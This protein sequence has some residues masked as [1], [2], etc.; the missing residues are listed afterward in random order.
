MTLTKDHL[1]DSLYT[2][3]DLPKGKSSSLIETL[4][5]IMKNQ[6]ENKEDILISGFGKFCVKDKNDRRGRNPATGEDLTLE[7]RRVVVFK[8][9]GILRK[10]I[11]GKGGMNLQR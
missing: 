2:S 11:N 8:C 9:S 5:E 4:L 6:L 1:V 7:A 10:K 3:L